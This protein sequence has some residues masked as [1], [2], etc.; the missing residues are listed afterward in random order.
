[1]EFYTSGK[2]YQPKSS[3]LLIENNSSEGPNPDFLIK[4]SGLKAMI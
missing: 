3:S 1:M 2:P 4:P